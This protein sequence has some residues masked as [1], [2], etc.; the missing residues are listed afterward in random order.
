LRANKPYKHQLATA[1]KMKRKN[2]LSIMLAFS[3]SLSTDAF[4]NYYCSGAVSYLGVDRNGSVF[5]ALENSTKIHAICNMITQDGYL[6]APVACKTAYAALLSAKISA[7]SIRLYYED[8]G[9]SCNTIP[10]WSGIPSTYFV[11][12]PY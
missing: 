12:G 7:R 11:E 10:D 1:S 6:M 8:N 2:I 5:V 4:A 3:A 9:Y